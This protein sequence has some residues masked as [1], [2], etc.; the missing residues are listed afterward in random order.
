[1]HTVANAA[2][3]YICDRIAASGSNASGSSNS[4]QKCNVIQ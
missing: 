2:I 4:G 3:R 1:M